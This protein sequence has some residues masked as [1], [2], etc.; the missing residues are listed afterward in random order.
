VGTGDTDAISVGPGV[1]EAGDFLALTNGGRLSTL[2][3]LGCG[4]AQFDAGGIGRAALIAPDGGAVSVVGGSA[5]EFPT[6][7]HAYLKEYYRLTYVDGV[8]AQGEANARSVLPFLQFATYDG[9]NRWTVMTQALLGDPELRVWTAPPRALDV[10]HDRHAFVTATAFDVTVLENSAP[11]EGARVAAWAAGQFLAVAL[12]DAT[13]AASVPI[14]PTERGAFKLTVTAQDAR[15]Y[16]ATV[17]IVGDERMRR[18]GAQAQL[19]RGVSVAPVQLAVRVL[20]RQPVAD[21]VQLELTLTGA[22][23]ARLEVLDLAGRSIASHDLQ[24]TQPGP[25]AFRLDA[26]ARLAPGLYWLRL[27]E[28]GHTAGARMAVVR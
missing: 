11:L 28:D 3:I 16:E 10:S 9:V 1:L 25:L 8:S 22:G 7:L 17:R 15:P 14:E 20:G 12:T 2:R 24:A 6:A 18:P 26:T 5:N 21:A 13:G 19:D 4:A 23:D 27:T